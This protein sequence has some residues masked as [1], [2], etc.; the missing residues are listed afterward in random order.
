M[1][2]SENVSLWDLCLFVNLTR[3]A[4]DQNDNKLSSLWKEFVKHFTSRSKMPQNLLQHAINMRSF[5]L[6]EFADFMTFDD[7]SKLE[8]NIICEV[9]AFNDYFKDVHLAT[10]LINLNSNGKKNAYVFPAYMTKLDELRSSQ[11]Q[12]QDDSLRIDMNAS[13]TINKDD[14]SAI[15][16]KLIDTFNNFMNIAMKDKGK[17]QNSDA[18]I[19]STREMSLPIQKMNAE[20]EHIVSSTPVIQQH[21]PQIVQTPEQPNQIK[22]E[23]TLFKSGA[24]LKL[25]REGTT[26]IEGILTMTRKGQK[27]TIQFTA[28]KKSIVKLKTHF[29]ITDSYPNH[30]ISICLKGE[31]AFQWTVMDFSNGDSGTLQIS[32]VEFSSSEK[33]TK[34]VKVLSAAQKMDCIKPVPTI[35]ESKESEDEEEGEIPAKPSFEN[36][37]LA[38]KPTESNFSLLLLLYFFIQPQTLSSLVK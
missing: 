16:L 8:E 9:C 21:P 29:E 34:F 7:L 2:S 27:Y 12:Q 15:T 25:Q 4:S 3:C 32:E 10:S 19:T 6:N 23:K 37:V 18:D 38:T 33:L 30:M 22:T 36:V 26:P 14:S 11:Q 24:I 1:L 5:S 35:E 28:E 31:S 17:Q 20:R 13:Q